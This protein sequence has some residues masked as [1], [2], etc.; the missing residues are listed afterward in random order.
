MQGPPP[1]ADQVDEMRRCVALILSMPPERAAGSVEVLGKL[2]GNLLSRPQAS[3]AGPAP[4][5]KG[6]PT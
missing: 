2:L 1:T 4:A 5:R 6:A 3:R